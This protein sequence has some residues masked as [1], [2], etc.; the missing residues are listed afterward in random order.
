MRR[1][2]RC[3]N[4]DEPD[5]RR[6]A[7]EALRARRRA[8]RASGGGADVERREAGGGRRSARRRRATWALVGVLD[9]EHLAGEV[10]EARRLAAEVV[11][12]LGEPNLAEDDHATRTQLLGHAGVLSGIGVAQREIARRRVHAL[13]VDQVL[14]DRQT[15]RGTA[16]VTVGTLLVEQR[17]SLS[18]CL[19][20]WVTA[21]RPGPRFLFSAA[22]R[23]MYA[24]VSGCAAISGAVRLCPLH[25]G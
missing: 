5:R 22:M 23:V 4:G 17:S 10:A 1:S 18:A 9:V 19:L 3:R 8:D 25:A 24:R 16:D 21:L 6:Q 12:E 7:D 11:R 2:E 20:S 13:D 14:T 15:V